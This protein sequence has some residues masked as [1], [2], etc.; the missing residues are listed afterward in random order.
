MKSFTGF[1]RTGK[2]FASDTYGVLPDIMTMAKA[3]T[4]GSQ[5][6]GAV[7]VRKHIY[8]K[9][10]NEPQGKGIEFLHGYTYS[11]HPAACAAALATLDIYEKENIFERVAELSPYFLEK[12]ATLSDIPA[13]SDIRGYGLIAG[14]DLK[15]QGA[16][17]M[18]GLEGMAKLFEA[19][20]HIKFTGDCALISPPLVCEKSH[21]DQI[22]ET[23]REVYA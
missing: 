14:I 4:N 7:A 19:G 6:M 16:P 18:A 21:I 23:F 2:A 15:P 11:G 10:V 1:G 13:F 8:D 5:P 17:G 3:L 20:L 22:V 9:L 12:I